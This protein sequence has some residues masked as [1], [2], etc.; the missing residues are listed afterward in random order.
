MPRGED[1]RLPP[2]PLILDVTMTHA[3]YGRTPLHTNGNLT[4]TISSNGAPQPDGA[5]KNAARKKILHYRQLSARLPDPIVF[6]PVVV[7][8]SGRLYDDVLRLLFLDTHR[9]ASAL[10]GELPEESDQFRFLCAECL[11]KLKGSVGLILAKA[12]AMRVTIP[13]DLST[14]TIIHLPRFFRSRLTRPLLTPS[15][16]LF[17]QRSA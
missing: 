14:R 1:T 13:L 17:P 4:H 9:G 16:D 2:R 8:T 15:L 5:L 11:E 12:S 7:N 3:R 10:A 6:M